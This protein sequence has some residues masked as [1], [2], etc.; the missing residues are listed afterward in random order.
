MLCSSPCA[1]VLREPFRQRRLGAGLPV[2]GSLA[3]RM[4]L[5]SLDRSEVSG[6]EEE[7]RI[8]SEYSIGERPDLVD[9]THEV[10]AVT[11]HPD[12]KEEV[13]VFLFGVVAYVEKKASI[14]PEAATASGS[15]NLDGNTHVGMLPDVVGNSITVRKNNSL[16]LHREKHVFDLLFDLYNR[17][18][19]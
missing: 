12:T 6:N 10:T 7:L 9:Q 4:V 19:A 16:V 5:Y 14:L 3:S 17:R 15:Y 1:G 8:S 18:V 13:T 2:L 11:R